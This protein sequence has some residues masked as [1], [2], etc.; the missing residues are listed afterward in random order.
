[1]KTSSLTFF[2]CLLP[3]PAFATCQQGP[4]ETFFHDFARD[5]AVQEAVAPERLTLSQLDH[6]AQ[7]EPV[8]VTREVARAD[9]EFPL[10]PNLTQF[11]RAGGAVR[12]E[13]VEGGHAATLTGDSGYLMTFVFTQAPCW[14]L[15]AIRDDSM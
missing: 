4:F 5:I 3:L 1:M 15:A 11:E 8:A 10:L 13:I 7:P 14:H 2:A 6:D 9:L 12:Y